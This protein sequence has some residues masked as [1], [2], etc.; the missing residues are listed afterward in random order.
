MAVPVRFEFS[1]SL[2]RLLGVG[3]D[4]LEK[5]VLG[6]LMFQIQPESC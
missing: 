5:V 1:L 4:S 2:N 6:H 3:K